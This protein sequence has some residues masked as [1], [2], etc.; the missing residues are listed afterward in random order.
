VEILIEDVYL[1]VVPQ[2]EIVDAEEE[3]QRAQAA[4]MER[5]ESAELLHMRNQT[6]VSSSGEDT[7]N[8]YI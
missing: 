4:K 3:E 6:N 8:Q 1:L 7:I 2:Q 5:L